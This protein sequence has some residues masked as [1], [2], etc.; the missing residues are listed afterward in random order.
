MTLNNLQYEPRAAQYVDPDVGC[1]LLP[2]SDNDDE[3]GVGHAHPRTGMRLGSA[4]RRAGLLVASLG[5][6]CTLAAVGLR[7]GGGAGLAAGSGAGPVSVVIENT[8][9]LQSIATDLAAV[10]AANPNW[11]PSYWDE[12]VSGK[13]AE[14]SEQANHQKTCHGDEELFASLCYKKCTI[15]TGNEYPVRSTAFTCCKETP[16]HPFN[17]RKDMGFCSGFSVA[18]GDK[19]AC[20]HPPT[21]CE[22]DEEV[23]AGVCYKT[24]SGL[25]NNE[26]PHRLT[27][28]ACC[29]IGM[30]YKCLFNGNLKVSSSFNV[31]SGVTAME[32][33][34]AGAPTTAPTVPVLP[35]A[36]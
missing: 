12:L 36:R 26:F 1:E 17:T 14:N 11:D 3:S 22:A 25:T 30:S 4:A 29:K 20:P 35:V 5:L 15:L 19:D 18:G 21:G 28:M 34:P 31:G 27:N 13:K 8:V 23:T 24:C 7:R 32:T 33:P 10:Q 6:C 9:G 2:Q 16:C